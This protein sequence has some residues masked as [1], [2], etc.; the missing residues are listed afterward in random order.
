M[1]IGFI[2]TSYLVGFLL[3]IAIEI[4][5]LSMEEYFYD[6]DDDTKRQYRLPSAVVQNV[7][8]PGEWKRWSRTRSK[9]QR[10]IQFYFWV[11][12]V[13]LK[14]C[15]LRYFSYCKIWSNSLHMIS[16]QN[17]FPSKYTM[18]FQRPSDVHNVQKKLNWCPNNVLC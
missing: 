11:L 4:P 6:A 9:S 16:I 17:P 14:V 13:R 10:M 12:C 2:V 8:N 1:Y 7:P 5:F 3:S 15:K 18:L